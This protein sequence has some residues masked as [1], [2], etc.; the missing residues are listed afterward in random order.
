MEWD[1]SEGELEI[2]KIETSLYL[3]ANEVQIVSTFVEDINEVQIVKT[4]ATPQMEIQTITLSPP[5]GETEISSFHSFSL[6]LDTTATGGSLQYSRQ[7]S[8]T[9][10]AE[11]SRSSLSKILGAMGNMLETPRIVKS[12][13]NSDGG[14]TY[15]IT[16]PI[17]MKNVPEIGVYASDIPVIVNSLEDGCVKTFVQHLV[18][19]DRAS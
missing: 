10:T 1:T 9:A 3:D 5:Y 18:N 11:G 12:N 2:Q 15:T 19:I 6:A 13:M 4:S 8:A 7:I 17:S 14:H 16:F